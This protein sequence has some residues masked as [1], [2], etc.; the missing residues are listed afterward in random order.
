MQKVLVFDEATSSLDG[1][2][3]KNIMEAIHNFSGQKTIIMVAH[4]LKTVQKM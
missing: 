4:R 1:I 3:E 2:T